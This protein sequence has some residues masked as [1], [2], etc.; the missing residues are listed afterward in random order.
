MLA[1]E[2]LSDIYSKVVDNLHHRVDP[3]QQRTVTTL[4]IISHKVRPTMTK[5]IPSKQPNITEDDDGKSPSSLQQDV[6]MSPSGTQNILS[7]VPVPPPMVQPDQYLRVN[8]EGPS[9][10]LISRGRKNSIP[11]YAL[12]AQFQQVREANAVT[13]QIFGVAQEYRHPVKFPDRKIWE[14]SF[15]HE[16]GQLAQGIITVKGTNKVIFIPKTQVTK[17]KKSL[18]EK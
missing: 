8:T 11:N 9:Y 13:H 2:Q 4:T 7:D 18:M 12:I 1:I 15:A 16:L 3:P 5:P 17:D 14:R 6:H 10:N